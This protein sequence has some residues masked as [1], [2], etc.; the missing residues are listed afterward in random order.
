M[1]HQR[2]VSIKSHKHPYGEEEERVKLNA[3][4]FS[5]FLGTILLSVEGCFGSSS[6]G[7]VS[8]STS[9]EFSFS[10]LSTSDP[11]WVKITDQDPFFGSLH[12]RQNII[13]RFLSISSTELLLLQQ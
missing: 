13:N 6:T 5:L 11:V 12:A 7:T 2:V 8:T 9:D 1:L 3:K 4:I 10:F